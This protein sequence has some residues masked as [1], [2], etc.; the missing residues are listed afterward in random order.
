MGIDLPDLVHLGVIRKI[1]YNLENLGQRATQFLF[2]H[3]M[4]SSLFATKVCRAG[5]EPT[6]L[7]V[8][9]P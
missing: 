8:E 3:K 5:L 9:M 7:F 6:S 1:Q 4:I 2:V